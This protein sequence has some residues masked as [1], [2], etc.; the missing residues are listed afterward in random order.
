[1][2][3]HGVGKFVH[4]PELK[5]IGSDRTCYVSHF[6]L[7]FSELSNN[8]ERKYNLLPCT[9]WNKAAEFIVANFK[10]GDYIEIIDSTAESFEKDGNKKVV[11]RINNF[12]KIPK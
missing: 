5:D 3:C 8:N 12:N 2:H 10:T 7:L 6:N 1:M 11:F 4:D 9:I